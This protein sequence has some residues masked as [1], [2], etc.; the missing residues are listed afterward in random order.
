MQEALDLAVAEARRAGA[1][2]VH[3]L[4][5]RVGALS[6]VVPEALRF[7]FDALAPGSPAEGGLLEIEPIAAVWRCGACDCELESG[8]ADDRCPA[9][10]N[11]AVRLRR[12]LELELATVEVS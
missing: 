10:G 5:L 11:A 3:R 4:R 8:P 9:C 6:G 2:R 1:V 7:A 12:G